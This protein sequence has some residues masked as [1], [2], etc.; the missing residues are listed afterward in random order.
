M[1]TCLRLLLGSS[2][3]LTAL[4]ILLVLTLTTA[5]G[6]TPTVTFSE[7]TDGAVNVPAD[8]HIQAYFSEAM[9]PSAINEQSFTVNRQVKVKQI[10]AG[11]YHNVVLRSDGT[12]TVWGWDRVDNLIP[13][14]TLMEA[15]KGLTGVT[16]VAAGGYH[17]VAVKND[18]TVAAWGLNN[19]GQATPPP[20][21]TGVIAVSAGSHHTVALKGDGTVVAWGHNGSKQCDVPAGLTGVKAIAAGAYFNLALKGDGTV[22]GWGDNGWYQTR[23]P[24]GLSGVAAIAAGWNHSLAVKCDGTVVAWGAND[25]GQSS[26]PAGL[27]E[28]I[29]IAGA[30]YGNHSVALKRDGTVVAWGSNNKGQSSVPVGLSGV[31]AITAGGFHTLALKSDCTVTGWGDGSYGQATAPVESSEITAI[32][33]GNS[34][35]MALKRDGTLVAWGTNQNVPAGLSGVTA[36][37]AAG[38][39]LAL[40]NDGTV[41][42]WGVSSY[43]E[44]MTVPVGLSGVKA[45]AAGGHNSLALRHDGTVVEWGNTSF[46]GSIPMPAGLSGVVAIAAGAEYSLALKNDGTVVAWGYNLHG[47]LGE[48]TTINRLSPTAVAGLTGVTIVAAGAFHSVAL[49]NDGTLAAW[50]H[51][52]Y[53]QLGSPDGSMFPHG[54][55]SLDV[56]PPLVTPD[57]GTGTYY[58]SVTVTLTCSDHFAGCNGIYYTEDG[59]T[60]TTAATPYTG[61]LTVSSSTTLMFIARDRVGNQSAVQSAVYTVIPS[62]HLLAVTVSGSGTI[63][64]PA[65]PPTPDLNCSG[66]CSQ[67]YNAGTVVTLNAQPDSSQMFG[68]WSGAC[69]GNNLSCSV[70]MDTVKAVTA[71]FVDSGACLAKLG[72]VCYGTLGAAYQAVPVNS[73]ADILARAGAYTENLIF[74]RNVTVTLQG[75]YDNGF[76]SI[77]GSTTLQMSEMTMLNGSLT[78]GSNVELLAQ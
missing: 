69:S 62:T 58:G 75:G 20:G 40:K 60:P 5:A 11:W 22:V 50:G 26:V 71:T 77:T 33:A 32:A 59:S 52:L 61:P 41:V 68:G 25:Y 35:I 3:S 42:G 72:T 19:Y 14:Y 65:S 46:W 57:Q 15:P 1:K 43:G 76:T 8:T 23:V 28:V 17:S 12:V 21:L 51:N 31:T 64:A 54:G 30:T 47:Q 9:D 67:S 38:H 16:A 10:A 27:S 74:D 48:G 36:I 24:A 56:L 53:G 63:S 13:N 18:G 55:I 49:K 29:A 39:A 34:S 37:A 73:S 45:I 70:T 66:A 44:A 2:R 78:V 6:A 4:A 7:P